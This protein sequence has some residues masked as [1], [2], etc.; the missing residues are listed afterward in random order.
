MLR[1]RDLDPE[2]VVAFFPC[3]HDFSD[4]EG[5]AASVKMA[6]AAAE[7]PPGPVVLLGIVPDAPEVGYGWIEPG[8]TSGLSAGKVLKVRRFWEKP[9]LNLASSLMKSGCL[10]NSFV[11]VGRVE[12]FLRLIRRA[13]PEMLDEFESHGPAFCPPSHGPELLDLF[14][15]IR[16]SNF[17]TEVLAACPDALA[18]LPCADL[19]WNDLGETSRV[20]FA[21]SRRGSKPAWARGWAIG[22]D[23]VSRAE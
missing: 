20:L 18:V 4:E 23:V 2:A 11:M 8:T 14:S 5:F 3:D 1:L 16:S 17:S 6:F 12:S 22:W 19:G 13:L 10:W 9:S 7:C 21:L 15:S